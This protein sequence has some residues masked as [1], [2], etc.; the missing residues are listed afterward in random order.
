M[1]ADSIPVRAQAQ[2]LVQRWGW[3]ATS[4]QTLSSGFEYWLGDAGCV[5]YVELDSAWV[6]AGAPLGETAN[7]RSLSH[8]FVRAAARR[9]KRACFFGVEQRFLRESGLRSFLLGEQP[10]YDPRRWRGHLKASRS[11]REQLR[12]ARA[13][14]V[15]VKPSE[16]EADVPELRELHR[17]WLAQRPLAS[18]GFL[19]GLDPF[20]WRHERRYFVA[21]SR[22]GSALAFAALS[23]VYARGG[24]L[25]EHLVRAPKAPNGTIELLV[26]AAM[27]ELGDDGVGWATLGLA[28]LSG[29][30]P[31]ALKLVRRCAGPLYNFEGLRAFKAKLGPI[32]WDSVHLAY[33]STQGACSSLCDGLSAF[34]GGRPLE[35][36][37]QSLSKKLSSLPHALIGA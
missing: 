35:F 7:L 9:G 18:M 15:S 31:L 25:F 6:G 26:D 30:V 23:P 16:G 5:A 3:N 11:L 1:T 20:T 17:T 14:G 27:N 4:F 8:E 12:R 28:P 13:K 32:A 36:A 29:D 10:V 37:T 24:W 19:T 33:P 21:R 22:D 34:A 2:Q